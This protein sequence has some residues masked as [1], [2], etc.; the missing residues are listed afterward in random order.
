ML[1]ALLF[2][3]TPEFPVALVDT[4]SPPEAPAPEPPIEEPEPEPEPEP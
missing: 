4:A 1:I 3:C 2:A